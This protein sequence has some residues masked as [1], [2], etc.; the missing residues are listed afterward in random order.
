MRL[1][2]GQDAQRVSCAPRAPLCTGSWLR[3][4]RGRRHEKS[5]GTHHLYSRAFVYVRCYTFRAPE[6][7]ARSGLTRRKCMRRTPDRGLR[8]YNVSA[9]VT[10]GRLAG[11]RMCSLQT[12]RGATAHVRQ[13]V[14]LRPGGLGP[15]RKR[16][17]LEVPPLYPPQKK[18]TKECPEMPQLLSNIQEKHFRMLCGGGDWGMLEYTVG[19]GWKRARSK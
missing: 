5:F 9:Y 13:M 7:A 8:V 10:V 19:K 14:S 18:A 4:R 15:C 16:R 12:W 3:V 1:E 17:H 11:R 2:D 6:R